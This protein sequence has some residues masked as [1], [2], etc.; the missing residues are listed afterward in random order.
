MHDLLHIDPLLIIHIVTLCL[1]K[2]RIVQ[3]ESSQQNTGENSQ[4]TFKSDEA[5]NF[6]V[7]STFNKRINSP[8]RI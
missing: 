2:H 8:K 3:C 4:K 1:I 6:I 7:E 5:S